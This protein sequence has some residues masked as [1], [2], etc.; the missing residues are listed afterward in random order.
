MVTVASR[1][2]ARRF[3]NDANGEG[4]PRFIWRTIDG[5][6]KPLSHIDQTFAWDEGEGDRTR[7]WW[8]AAHCRYFARQAAR[9]GFELD[10]DIP[11][12]FERFDVVWPLDVADYPARVSSSL[13]VSRLLRRHGNAPLTNPVIHFFRFYL[14]RVSLARETV[15]V[16]L[17]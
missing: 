7:E 3:R 10:D 13:S 4:H 8:L 17:R 6:I 1:S 2:E 5:T 15:P 11:T 16:S 12:V 9:E 14:E